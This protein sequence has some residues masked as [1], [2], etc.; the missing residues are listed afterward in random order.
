[1]SKTTST[2][3]D[4]A[5]RLKPKPETRNNDDQT[6]DEFI[7]DLASV[8]DVSIYPESTLIAKFNRSCAKN[9]DIAGE[10]N[11]NA[12]H[13][14]QEIA[15][16]RAHMLANRALKHSSDYLPCVPRPILAQ[17]LDVKLGLLKCVNQASYRK[18][19]QPTEAQKRKAMQVVRALAQKEKDNRDKL[20]DRK[21]NRVLFQDRIHSESIARQMAADEK[22]GVQT[23]L[24]HTELRN[25]SAEMEQFGTGHPMLDQAL[26]DLH[27]RT[28]RTITSG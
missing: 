22:L 13:S 28:G 9:R 20:R 23:D 15:V 24:S 4:K 21:R 7:E 11:P 16:I 2:P 8:I 12:Q 17:H 10:A 6:Y 18:D 19:A 25:Q 14:D 5:K 26:N 3:K 27:S 1:M